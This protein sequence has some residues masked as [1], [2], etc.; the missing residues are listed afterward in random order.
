MSSD[1]DNIITFRIKKKLNK[2][3]K[4]VIVKKKF[5]LIIHNDEEESE[6][7]F[8]MN[9]R[10]Q[11]YYDILCEVAEERDFKVLGKYIKND[12]KIEMICP[13]NHIFM[14]TAHS[15][16]SGKGCAKC[17]GT[18][19]IQAKEIFE[20]EAEERGFEIIDEYINAK[21]KIQMKCPNNHIFE[22]TPNSF[23][24]KGQGC[25]QCNMSGIASK[26]KQILDDNDLKYKIEHKINNNL[27]YD[28]YLIDYNCII[29]VDGSQH[30]NYNEYFH[31]N[32]ENFEEARQRDIVK[33]QQCKNLDIPIIR[34]DYKWIPKHTNDEIYNFI[35]EAIESK[36]QLVL[37]TPEIYDWIKKKL[38]KEIYK[39]YND[40]PPKRKVKLI[41]NNKE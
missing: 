29:E 40:K 12:I 39:K 2:D 35:I 7:D 36:D 10:Q 9:A 5:K 25:N 11:K 14:M 6:D 18:C 8:E 16:K 24:N 38:P 33:Y 26:I 21:T 41:I 1:N 27:F 13:N 22:I 23:K 32:E 34:L 15:F 3:K 31:E 4:D 20:N 19:P 37:S 17:S 28:F 30:F